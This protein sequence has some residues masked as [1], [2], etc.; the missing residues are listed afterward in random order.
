MIVAEWAKTIGQT[1]CYQA[2]MHMLMM[3]GWCSDA[4]VTS[5]IT[6]RLQLALSANITVIAPAS[7][8]EVL[9][10]DNVFASYPGASRY[11]QLQHVTCT[12]S[13]HVQILVK[14]LHMMF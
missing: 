11:S 4:F 6:Q 10:C 2:A 13:I 8:G 14:N 5:A 9:P 7:N 12:S 1:N 3:P